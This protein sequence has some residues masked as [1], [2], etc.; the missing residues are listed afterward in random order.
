MLENYSYNEDVIEIVPPKASAMIN[1]FRA[2]GYDLPSAIADIIDNSITAKAKNIWINYHWDGDKSRLI[3]KDD[4]LGMSKLELIEGMTP[5]SKNPNDERSDDD[6]G[7]F[8]LGL[9]TASFSQCKMLTVATKKVD[10]Q[11]IKRCWDLDFVN[12]TGEWKLLDFISDINL[13]DN[14]NDVKSGTV[15]IWEKL[16]RLIGEDISIDN[17]VVKS[18]FL[19]KIEEVE[20]H[21]SM[22]FHRYIEKGKINLYMNGYKLDPWDPFMKG[23]IGGEVLA[24]EEMYNGRVKVKGYILPHASNL[25]EEQLKKAEGHQGWFE[26]QGF[27][28]Y[29]NERLLIHGGW[30]GMFPK[31][32]H[33]KL[34]RVLI[35]I[36]N[37]TD[38]DWQI[39]IK[40]ST[41]IPPSYLRKDLEKV[42]LIARKKASE[43][44]KFRGKEV[45]RRANS[46]AI[47]AF[48]PL[49]N[50]V[51][52]RENGFLYSINYKHQL[53]DRILNNDTITKKEVKQV[54]DFVSKSLPV[55]TIIQNQYEDP[56]KHDL[57]KPF[58][59][60]DPNTVNIARTIYTM[61]LNDG[62]SQ[63]Q[64]IQHILNMEPFNNYP[65][66]EDTLRN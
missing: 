4:G 55:E 1:T 31:M 36:P 17:E 32:E 3:I 66:L 58:K 7:R 61:K 18:V 40:K 22:V 30:L 33:Y 26:S 44:H 57:R 46:T 16:D 11:V 2:I 6:L 42:A 5:G 65:Q 37:N 28:V 51:K 9:K 10:M 64:A 23:V 56:Q 34:A 29:R 35:D 19:E 15:V 39:D 62:L 14:L 13:L 43:V 8:G 45:M 49:W 59:E 12:K 38:F 20:R 52:T 24:T 27:Y 63:D 47:G 50:V 53:I 60:L 25:S 48:Q 21:L 54:L 41:A